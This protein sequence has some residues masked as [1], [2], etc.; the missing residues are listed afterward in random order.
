MNNSAQ[1]PYISPDGVVY[2]HLTMYQRFC[3]FIYSNIAIICLMVYMRW[4]RRR[5]WRMVGYWALDKARTPGGVAIPVVKTQ[6]DSKDAKYIDREKA[7]EEPEDD[8]HDW[9]D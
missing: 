1:K 8:E 7:K 3:G 5:I 4:S 2:V 6:R 9:Q